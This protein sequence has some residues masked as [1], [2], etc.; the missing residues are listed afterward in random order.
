MGVNVAGFTD[1]ENV[2]LTM[3]LFRSRTYELRIIGDKSGT[4]VDTG[5]PKYGLIKIVGKFPKSLPIP[6]KLGM[7]KISTKERKVLADDI[8]KFKS[9][10]II[11]SISS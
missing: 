5:I 10:L 3:P 7:P 11:L 1:S 6:L 9:D 8:P 4:I 2:R